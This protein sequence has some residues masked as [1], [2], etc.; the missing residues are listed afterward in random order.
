MK[1]LL[2]LLLV[3]AIFIAM[4]AAA[5]P[6]GSVGPTVSELMFLGDAPAI[7]PAVM[8]TASAYTAIPV[9]LSERP[10]ARPASVSESMLAGLMCGNPTLS[11]AVIAKYYLGFDPRK[12]MHALARDQT[13]MA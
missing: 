7:K 8:V 6:P 11:T 4:P 2:F 9:C 12:R 13:C 3:M 10:A 1:K 5:G